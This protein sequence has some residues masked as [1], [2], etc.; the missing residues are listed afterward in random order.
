MPTQSKTLKHGY[1]HYKVHVEQ[2]VSQELYEN[3]CREFNIK[4]FDLILDGYEFDMGSNMGTLSVKRIDRSPSSLTVDWNET[5]KLKEELLSQGV[6]LYD[7]STG[8]G[9]KYHVYYT[10]KFYCRYLWTKSKCKVKNK[11]VYRFDASRGRKGN[12]E[13]LIHLL[14]TDDLAYLRFKKHNGLQIN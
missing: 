5:K 13:K 11:T 8:K 10:D 7:S 2:P 14:K 3:I 4:L 12:K 1:K 6:E 9:E